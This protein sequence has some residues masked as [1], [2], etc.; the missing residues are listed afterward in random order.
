MLLSHIALSIQ[1]VTIE[2]T[3]PSSNQIDTNAPFLL[4]PFALKI[5]NWLPYLTIGPLGRADDAGIIARKGPM[6]CVV[7]GPYWPLPEGYYEAVMQIDR[8]MGAQPLEHMV[9]ADVMTGDQQLVAANFH[10][11]AQC[12]ATTIRLPFEMSG[13]SSGWR[14]IETR[15]WSSGQEQF[16]IQSLSVKPLEQSDWRDLLPF[17]LLGEV[18]RRVSSGISN[19]EGRSG[20]IAYSPNIKFK[21]GY[22]QITFAVEARSTDQAHEGSEAYAIALVKWG[23]EILESMRSHQQRV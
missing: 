9:R 1:A 10:L 2:S 19:M 16:R 5:E 15:I 8:E 4:P 22:Y 14:Q 11:D 18:G 20:I 3:P 6:D 12:A 17:L 21:P 7:F 23:A 13:N